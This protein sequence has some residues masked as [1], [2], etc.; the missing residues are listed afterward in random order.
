MRVLIVDDDL[1]DRQ[2]VKRALHLG[3]V[4]YEL[5][6]AETVEEGLELFKQQDYDLLLVDYRMPGRDGIELVLTIRSES[7]E[8]KTAI[9]MMSNSE[10]E[11]IA[12]DSIR[13]GAQDFIL[14]N[15]I[16]AARMHRSILHAQTRFDLEK[17]LQDSYRKLKELAERDTLTG[18]A[19][20]HL[21]DESLKIFIAN[22]RR[23]EHRLALLLIDLDN[24]KFV[25]DNFGH[26]VGDLLLQRV[27]QRIHACLRGNEIFARLGGDEFAILLSNLDDSLEAS[28]VA[29][30]ILHVLE[31]PFDIKGHTVTS[32]ASIGIALHPD[33][34]E[35]PEEIL[36]FA[37]I[38]MYRAKK[39]GKN[40][41]CFFE[42]E[43][44]AQFI[45]RYQIEQDL[46]KAI[47]AGAFELRFQPV[48]AAQSHELGG[49]EVL[50]HWET[51]NG[52]QRPR[53]YLAVAED[54][55]LILQIGG[56]VISNAIRQQMAWKS[57]TG[58]VYPMSI[59]LSPVQL[60]DA[61]LPAFLEQLFSRSGA[62]PQHCIFEVEEA[63]LK[64]RGGDAGRSITQ[65]RKLG[66]KVAFDDYG[67]GASSISDL[68]DFPFDLVKL[69]P[70][71]LPTVQSTQKEVALFSSVVGML[72]ALN[73]QTVVVGTETVEQVELCCSL[74]VE[75]LQG[76]FFARPESAEYVAA[77]FLSRSAPN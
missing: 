33:N 74:G 24:F 62:D 71:F 63:A 59:N 57:L 4:S 1:V 27:V 21:F 3:S 15:E 61:S 16:T 49:F 30:R 56:W 25:N 31:K 42:P 10:E 58:V 26:G 35:Y 45:S 37:D 46:R 44:Q 47:D 13:A 29:K 32:G 28:N 38:A 36:K 76:H 66:C 14:K 54:S 6:E 40:Q 70:S 22:N 48:Y 72:K 8:K 2:I 18:L 75:Q 17:Q 41:A 51:E 60:A 52:V 11:Q 39:R 34:G 20:R 53:E 64:G 43:M 73:L 19:N 65:L 77:N 7:P 5:V 23:Q 55:K 50:L 9:V 68:R 69:D 67:A 12:L